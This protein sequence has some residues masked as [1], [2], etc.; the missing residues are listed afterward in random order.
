MTK[1]GC[2]ITG[3]MKKAQKIYLEKPERKQYVD[4]MIKNKGLVRK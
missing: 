4:G 1:F 2:N 3:Q